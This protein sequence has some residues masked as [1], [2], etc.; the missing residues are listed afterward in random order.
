[1]SDEEVPPFNWGRLVIPDDIEIG[2]GDGSGNENYRTCG[3]CG[4]DCEPDPFGVG[5]GGGIRVAF[6]CPNC[7]LHA[8]IDP[9]EHLR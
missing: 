3:G 8:V 1:M 4:T 7:G 2:I 5:E 6:V 9:F